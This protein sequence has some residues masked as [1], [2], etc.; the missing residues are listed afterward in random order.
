MKAELIRAL[1][2]E[3]VGAQP[4][5]NPHPLEIGKQYFIRTLTYHATGRV[6][7]YRG[8]F[9]LLEEAAWIA[10]SGRFS[11]AI[12]DHTLSEVEPV[13]SMGLNTDAI[14]DFFE[15]PGPLPTVQK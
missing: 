8:K 3:L 4:T 12:K 6:T 2:D 9:V 7:G 14:V 15:W 13:G 11:Q 1:L 10:D 5:S